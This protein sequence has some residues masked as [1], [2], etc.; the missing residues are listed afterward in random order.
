MRVC[1]LTSFQ[2]VIVK[3]DS[4][5]LFYKV[6]NHK[7][8]GGLALGC[9]WGELFLKS[10]RKFKFNNHEIKAVDFTK[11]GMLGYNITGYHKNPLN[12][13]YMVHKRSSPP[14]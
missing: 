13:D 10:A 1:I 7:S 2:V 8:Q 11:L 9:F 3:K 4:I 14:P 6:R 12:L 5:E